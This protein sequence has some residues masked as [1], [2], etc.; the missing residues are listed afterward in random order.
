MFDRGRVQSPAAHLVVLL[1]DVLGGHGVIL[2]VAGQVQHVLG[3]LLL[4]AVVVLQHGVQL[5]RRLPLVQR[6]SPGEHRSDA[7]SCI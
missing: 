1:D 5:C 6:Q 3:Q 4:Q 2:Q 7:R